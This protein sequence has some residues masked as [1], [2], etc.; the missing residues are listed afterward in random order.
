M[1]CLKDELDMRLA[2]CGCL[3]T[4]RNVVAAKHGNCIPVERIH[5]DVRRGISIVERA[6]REG[7]L[8]D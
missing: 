3:E 2:P 6:E 4:K 5:L 8:G 1:W 7:L